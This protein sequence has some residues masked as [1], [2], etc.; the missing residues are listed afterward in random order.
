MFNGNLVD[1]VQWLLEH[2]PRG[3]WHAL[4]DAGDFSPTMSES[5][6]LQP[7]QLETVLLAAKIMFIR[8]NNKCFSSDTLGQLKTNYQNTF[9]L[10]ATRCRLDRG[11]K[12]MTFICIDDPIDQH[13][14]KT[15]RA[16]CRI[17]P[18]RNNEL[19][20]SILD[21][22]NR[23]CEERA[24]QDEEENEDSEGNEED[25][26]NSNHSEND[27]SSEDSENEA[28][29]LSP[30]EQIVEDALTLDVEGTSADNQRPARSGAGTIVLHDKKQLDQ[31]AKLLVLSYATVAM[32]YSPR[33]SKEE[34]KRIALAACT[35]VCYDLG[36]RRVHGARAVEDWI[37]IVK[38]SAAAGR[39]QQVLASK[40][41]RDEKAK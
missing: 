5:L 37:R 4:D 39:T 26:N 31:T 19:D 29:Y 35:M 25:E 36:Y 27:L 18:R 10:H 7:Y 17:R 22:I 40:N 3:I 34:N 12:N 16:N 14:P 6:Q 32:G 38:S 33:K 1:L 21:R 30:Q 20:R 9:T 24:R 11:S 13:N 23:L 2:L 28:A 8:S 15:Q 41:T